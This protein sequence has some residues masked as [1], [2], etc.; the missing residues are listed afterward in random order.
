MMHDKFHDIDWIEL[1]EFC[2]DEVLCA[3]VQEQL[4]D[5]SDSEG[6]EAVYKQND[7]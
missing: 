4:E 1:A 7:D 6:L 2:G 3:C 5:C